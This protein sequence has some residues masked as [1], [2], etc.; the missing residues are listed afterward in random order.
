MVVKLYWP[1]CAESLLC[2]SCYLGLQPPWSSYEVFLINNLMYTK[3]HFLYCQ[4]CI[5]QLITATGGCLDFYYF[6]YLF[7]LQ[8]G[9]LSDLISFYLHSQEYFQ[10]WQK[11][12]KRISIHQP[13]ITV[14]GMGNRLL[15]YFGN[16][17]D[18]IGISTLKEDAPFCCI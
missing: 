18:I 2:G 17:S 9:S 12:K 13:W 3:Y 16:F 6:I 11:K 8:W 14:H 4:F 1:M 7:I 15:L 5:Q 10:K